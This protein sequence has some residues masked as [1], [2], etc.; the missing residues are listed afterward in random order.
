MFNLVTV[1][2]VMAMAA[3]V[4]N[5]TNICQYLYTEIEPGTMS[6]EYNEFAN[7]LKTEVV[8]FAS[9]LVSNILFLFLRAMAMQRIFLTLDNL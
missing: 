1:F 6:P 7:W 9:G 3:Q 4:L 5:I 8:V 2:G